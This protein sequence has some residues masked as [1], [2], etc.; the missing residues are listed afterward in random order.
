MAQITFRVKNVSFMQA[1]STRLVQRNNFSLKHLACSLC[2][3]QVMLQL[4]MKRTM[5]ARWRK[6]TVRF[7][8]K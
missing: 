6:A 8:I 2:F 7:F 4:G 1:V 3:N 5:R